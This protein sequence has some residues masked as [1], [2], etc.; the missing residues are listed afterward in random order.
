MLGSYIQSPCIHCIEINLNCEYNVDPKSDRLY[1]YVTCL[2]CG[3]KWTEFYELN[4]GPLTTWSDDI[5]K[6]LG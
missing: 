1:L 3:Y 4:S 6:R 5:N 2:N